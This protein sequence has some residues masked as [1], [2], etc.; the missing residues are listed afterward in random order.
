MGVG[1]QFG[2]F[3]KVIQILVTT[4]IV[5]QQNGLCFAVLFRVDAVLD[6]FFVKTRYRPCAAHHPVHEMKTALELPAKD[7]TLR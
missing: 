3:I 5:Q 7:P 6:H 1:Q 2:I 4:N